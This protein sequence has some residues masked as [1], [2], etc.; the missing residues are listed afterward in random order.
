[1]IILALLLAV[2]SQAPTIQKTPAPRIMTTTRLVTPTPRSAAIS[3]QSSSGAGGEVIDLRT[4]DAMV[5]EQRG[6]ERSLS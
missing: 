2:A 3:V 4:S 5:D 1:M 6:R